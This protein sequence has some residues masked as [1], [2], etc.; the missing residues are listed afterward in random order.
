MKPF[1]W[2]CGLSVMIGC[3]NVE[4]TVFQP[5]GRPPLTSPDALDAVIESGKRLRVQYADAR[6]SER[7]Q[8]GF[9][10]KVNDSTYAFEPR[11]IGDTSKTDQILLG[12]SQIR[13]VNVIEDE[14]LDVRDAAAMMTVVALAFV[15]IILTFSFSLGT[16]FSL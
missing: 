3:A 7:R 6:G 15:T 8:R 14:S 4:R 5:N 16:P 1:L 2:L 12:L 13:R 11:R 9:L 10:S